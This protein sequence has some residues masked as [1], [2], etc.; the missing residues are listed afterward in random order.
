MSNVV[1]FRK[2]AT[3][4]RSDRP[5]DRIEIYR[6][7]FVDDTLPRDQWPFRYF[8]NLIEEGPEGGEICLWSGDTHQEAIVEAREISRDW[9]GLPIVEHT[10]GGTVQ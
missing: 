4:E 5:L 8:L 9:G 10:N 6:G 7:Q 1:P 2:P 3:E